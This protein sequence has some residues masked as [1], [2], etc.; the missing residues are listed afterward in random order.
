MVLVIMGVTASGKTTVGEALAKRLEWVFADADD[1]HSLANREKMHAGIPLTD[2]DRGPWLKDLHGLIADWIENGINGI[3][4]CSA[5]KQEYRD[6]LTADAPQDEIR[7][8]FLNGSR[9]LIEERAEHRHH[10]FATPALVPSQLETLEVPTDALQINIGSD[11][12][13][14]KTVDEIVEEIISRLHIKTAE[15][16]H[17]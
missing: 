5:L 12:S 2:V 13:S 9:E 16:F 11:D 3:L 14:A 10:A 15:Q 8:I 7:F 17:A 6:I 4:A 1:Y